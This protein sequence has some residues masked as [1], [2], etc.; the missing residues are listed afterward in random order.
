M[1]A[2]KAIALTA[3][4]RDVT[5]AASFSPSDTELRRRESEQAAY[6]RGRRDGE[7][8]LSAQLLQQRSEILELHQGV[9]NSLRNTIPQLV[10]ETEKT[11]IDL[12]MQVAQRIVA[13][14]PITIE[15]VEAVVR[16]AVAQLEDQ[17]EITIQL[18]PED[19]ALLRKHQSPILESLPEARALRYSSSA[20]VT[21]GGCVVHTQFGLL[22]A[23]RET[24]IVQL[25]KSLAA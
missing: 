23:R 16:E 5:L 6:E 13:N 8:A 12:A 15:T 4:I 7:K 10:H 25:R 2:Y 20:E 19:L 17:T 22:D 14:T 1:K 18:H 21:R 3:P 11:L 9:V 24:K